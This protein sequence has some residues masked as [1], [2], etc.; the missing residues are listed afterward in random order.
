MGNAISKFLTILADNYFTAKY[1]DI[2][3]EVDNRDQILADIADMDGLPDSL[4]YFEI[5]GFSSSIELQAYLETFFNQFKVDYLQDIHNKNRSLV[6]EIK[7]QIEIIKCS[8]EQAV[9]KSNQI[10]DDDLH[11]LIGIKINFLDELNKFIVDPKKFVK[12]PVLKVSMESVGKKSK[13]YYWQKGQKELNDLYEN[14]KANN[15]ISQDTIP[16]DFKA[17]F[18]EK[19]LS[20]LKPIQ[21]EKGP[22]LLA[23]FIDQLTENKCIPRTPKWSLLKYC[24]TYSSKQDGIYVPAL[25]NIK[26]QMHQVKTSG[27]PK[28]ARLVDSLFT[29]ALEK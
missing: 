10:Q 21:W 20:T 6:Q 5:N 7:N 17:V 22:R 12:G 1:N 3:D 26:S 18:S 28:F 25:E 24:F 16:E 27:K 29:T 4:R 23:Y 14:M 15:L 11:E 9:Y 19:D 13:S 2:L 8:L